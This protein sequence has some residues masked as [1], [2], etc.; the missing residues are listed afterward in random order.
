MRVLLALS[1]W[2]LA[3]AAV[4]AKPESKPPAATA[5]APAA[6]APAPAA[7]QA[8]APTPALS[9]NARSFVLRDFQSNQVLVSNSGDEKLEPASLTKLMTAY[10][11][12]K[13]LK[14]KKLLETQTLPVS[15]KAWKAIGSRMF[16]DPKT[17]VTVG[18]L[19]RGMIIQ[20][21]NDASV[22]LAEGVAGAE[23]TFA[24]M[25]NKEAARLGMKNTHY[26]NATGLP[27][28]QHYST[29]EDLSLLAAA[30]A[31]DFPEYY[32]IYATRE[33]RYN[34]ITQPN[35]NRL[36]W[37]DPSVDGMKTGHTEA[38]GYCLVSSAKRG[39][40]RL[41]AVVMGT[42]SESVRA[43]ESQKLL[44]YGFQFF[45]TRRMYKKD[46]SVSQ[47]EV[48][49]GQAKQL[50]AGFDQDIFLSLPRQDFDKLKAMLTTTQPLIAPLNRGD[51]VGKIKLTLDD[52]A[53]GEYPVLALESVPV[54]SF[55]GR[56]WDA[57]RLMFK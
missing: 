43:T 42:S 21:G 11:T 56:T 36:L 53:I 33:Y 26:L 55:F 40:R 25:M 7:A 27:D 1:V 46:D 28:S 52:K 6:A 4:A 22:A 13:A 50:K 44:N 16:I 9:I 57:V 2:F 31:R 23:E 32:P 5:P 54:G 35:R 41:V 45:D 34:N 17:P 49:K 15:V 12:F 19:M 48:Y 39:E 18:E 51:K 37:L 47:L 38:A 10:L 3:T 29:A 20:S 8:A 30:I 14:E 24:E